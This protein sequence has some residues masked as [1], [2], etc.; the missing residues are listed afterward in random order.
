M[1]RNIP[2][3]YVPNRPMKQVEETFKKGGFGSTTDFINN[4]FTKDVANQL[5]TIPPS[6][7]AQNQLQSISFQYLNDNG[8]GR[9]SSGVLSL[10]AITKVLK[11]V[12]VH[13]LTL[14]DQVIYTDPS[15]F[16]TNNQVDLREAVYSNL[17]ITQF[18]NSAQAK[19]PQSI[20]N[21]NVTVDN[22]ISSMKNFTFTYDNYID[23]TLAVCKAVVQAAIN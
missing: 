12:P 11:G 1:A 20:V 18:I 7:S 23:S 10:E 4:N 9:I 14:F 13:S 15:I 19:Y 2:T 21:L 16:Y 5:A 22:I 8:N 6:P 17:G 3:G